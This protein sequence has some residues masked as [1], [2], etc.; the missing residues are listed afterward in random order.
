MS[1]KKQPMQWEVRKL[2]DSRWGIFLKQQF[3]KT[4]EPVCYAASK[5][6][7]AAIARVARMNEESISNT[8]GD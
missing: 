8:P 3:C 2:P 4:D 6:E 5:T 1:K 7:A